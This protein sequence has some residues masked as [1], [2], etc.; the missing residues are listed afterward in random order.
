M[1]LSEIVDE[2][3][4]IVNDSSYDD[5]IIGYINQ[6]IVQASGEVNLPDLKRVGVATTVNDLMYTS[7]AG[8]PN[9]FNGRLSKLLDQSIVRYASL[10]VMLTAIQAQQRELTEN[11]AVEMVALEGKTLWYFPIPKPIQNITCVLFSDPPALVGPE[12]EPVFLPSTCHRNICIYGAAMMHYTKIEDGIEGDKVN[13]LHYATLYATGIQ[14]L[15]EW[16]GR[17]R[18]HYSTPVLNNSIAAY[19]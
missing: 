4:L 18:V 15:R 16:I 6:A 7:L 12:D 13:T 14:Q 3:K 19:A 11:G 8:L 10:E 9:G 17:H 2:V 5:S 1:N